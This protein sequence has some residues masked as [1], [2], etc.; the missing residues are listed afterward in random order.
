MEYC[1]SYSLC[2]EGSNTGIVHVEWSIWSNTFGSVGYG[3]D[4]ISC[5]FSPHSS[6]FLLSAQ[7]SLFSVVP[8]FNALRDDDELSRFRLVCLL[9]ED[10][11]IVKILNGAFIL[12][13]KINKHKKHKSIVPNK[14]TGIFQTNGSGS[15]NVL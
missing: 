6:N 7:P 4:F 12:Y 9:L 11:S 14:R 2:I 5:L 3:R 10:G 1:N 8:S 13:R 15:N